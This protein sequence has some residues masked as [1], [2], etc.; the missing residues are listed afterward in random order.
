MNRRQPIKNIKS[1]EEIPD[2]P[3]EHAEAEFWQFHS[4]VELFDQLPHAE[5]VEFTPVPKRLIPLPLDEKVYRQI[6]RM[7]RQRGIS[8]L[9]FIQRLIEGRLRNRKAVT[10]KNR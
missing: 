7:A 9:T 10:K 1:L 6:R 3:N 5:D 4:P 8:P 2:F